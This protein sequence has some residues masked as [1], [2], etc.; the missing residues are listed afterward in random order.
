MKHIDLRHIVYI[1]GDVKVGKTTIISRY[2][3]NQISAERDTHL[4]FGVKKMKIDEQI[5]RVQIWD[6]IIQ[7]D[8]EKT[9]SFSYRFY[10]SV[11]AIVFVYDLSNDDSFSC[12]KEW[13]TITSKF[14]HK[15]LPILLLGNK[16][17][18]LTRR[19]SK[20]EL[21]ELVDSMR[22]VTVAEISAFKHAHLSDT[23]TTF[24]QKF[25][26]DGPVPATIK[27]LGDEREAEPT[28]VQNI[29]RMLCWCCV[30]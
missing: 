23:I 17:D 5:V 11:N 24:I 2:C 20:T 26:R 7:S 28:T 27:E 3:G 22:N 13:Y 19:K 15:G 30:E 8:E 4:D 9:N 6:S 18:K 1:A 14:C 10:R 12:I 25:V 29:Q 16:K 21:K